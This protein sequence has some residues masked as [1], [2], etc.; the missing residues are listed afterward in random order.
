MAMSWTADPAAIVERMRHSTGRPIRVFDAVLRILREN[1][2]PVLDQLEIIPAERRPAVYPKA[3]HLA[4]ENI[5]GADDTKGWPR[6]IVGGAIQ[7]EEFAMGW[8]DT[9]QVN[10]T[11]AW[12]GPVVG[13]REFE[14]ALD[15]ACVCSGIFRY[16]QFHGPFEDPDNPGQI[17]WYQMMPNG[18]SLVPPDW[19]HYSGWI[20]HLVARQSPASNLW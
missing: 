1:L 13:R 4:G 16:P 18:Y 2:V 5:G 19:Q 7:E 20:A 3:Y 6:I 8:Q 17:L 10:V 14:E 11:V 9:I 15:M 12:P